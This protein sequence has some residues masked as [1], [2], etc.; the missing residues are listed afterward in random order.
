MSSLQACS[1]AIHTHGAD[2]AMLPEHVLS[3]RTSPLDR[4]RGSNPS[5]TSNKTTPTHGAMA[6]RT[7]QEDWQRKAHWQDEDFSP[8]Y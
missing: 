6:I 7:N 2:A 3:T 8:T 5:T 4:Q 1:A